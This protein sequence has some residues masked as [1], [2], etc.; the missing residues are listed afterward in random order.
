MIYQSKTRT[1]LENLDYNAFIVS[2]V[3][4]F[5]DLRVLAATNL[6]DDLVVVLRAEKS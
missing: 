6:L 2:G 4:T 1:W 3:D 5:V